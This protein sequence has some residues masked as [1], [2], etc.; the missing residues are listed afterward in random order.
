M[1]QARIYDDLGSVTLTT[2]FPYSEVDGQR[3]DPDLD[4]ISA[5]CECQRRVWSW[6]YQ[7][8][9]EDIEGFICRCV[10]AAWVFVPQLRD[11][12]MTEIA[13]R[14]GKK[15]QSLG[16]WVASFKREFPD[17]VKHIKHIRTCT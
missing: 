15:K 1:G 5:A 8:P 7:P 4:P 16:R 11:Y 9:C 3:Y 13:G 14:M 12:T 6:V 2:E 17:L 10:I